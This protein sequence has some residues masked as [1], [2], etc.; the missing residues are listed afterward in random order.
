M[1]KPI[2]SLTDMP[3]ASLKE[4]LD[5]ANLKAKQ[6]KSEK[7]K[8]VAELRRRF[9]SQL[10]EEL[11]KKPEPFGTAH[12]AA[13]GLDVKFDVGK[14]V[15][16][17]QSKLA[18]LIAEINA[19]GANPADYIDTETTYH[20][21]EARWSAWGANVQGS[22]VGARTVKEGTVSVSVEKVEE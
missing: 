7:A 11:K 21:P 4:K 12:I 10:S 19:D 14:K 3:L 15:E 18:A 9:A 17:D 6:A 5:A 20:I 22:F 13:D 8:V 1:A 2:Q 16:W